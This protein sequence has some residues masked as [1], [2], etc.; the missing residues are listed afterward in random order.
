MS[1]ITPGLESLLEPLLGNL[2]YLDSAVESG[3]AQD[4]YNFSNR[5][6][7]R[8]CLDLYNIGTMNEKTILFQSEEAKLSQRLK[9]IIEL[10]LKYM[11]WFQIYIPNYARTS[12]TYE[13]L[14]SEINIFKVRSGIQY[15]FDDWSNISGQLNTS[16]TN[17][18][19]CVSM[20]NQFDTILKTWLDSGCQYPLSTEEIDKN[21]P[22]SHWWWFTK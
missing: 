10:L 12:I 22:K 3:S 5:M 20:E 21:T 19:T 13:Q 6:F 17:L 1:T 11:F 18:S 8:I 7:A 9:E 14:Q 15:L 16:I 2:I 4:M